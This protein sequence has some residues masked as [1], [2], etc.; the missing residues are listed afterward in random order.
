MLEFPLELW[1][2]SI[3]KQNG[4]KIKNGVPSKT[5]SEVNNWLIFAPNVPKEALWAGLWDFLRLW[6]KI[7][8]ES[9]RRPF[10]IILLQ[11]YDVFWIYNI[12]VICI[13]YKNILLMIPR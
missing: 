4:L 7:F 8:K 2:K 13:L 12:D 5:D 1:F 9:T 11:C 6:I 10:E 3:L